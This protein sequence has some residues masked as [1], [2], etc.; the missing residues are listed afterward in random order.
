MSS[1]ELTPLP[2]APSTRR[3][4][5]G[6]DSPLSTFFVQVLD[7]DD[8]GE[9]DEVLW[10]GTDPH[11]ITEARTVLDLVRPYAAVSDG[12]EQALIAEAAAEGE[13]FAGR[14][15]TT[16]VGEATLT[17]VTDPDQAVAILADLQEPE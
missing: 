7:Q 10:R 2:G 14:V 9:T 15:G 13:R 5:I 11:E 6:W 17:R 3:I 1:H 16:L 4:H 8:E 12:L